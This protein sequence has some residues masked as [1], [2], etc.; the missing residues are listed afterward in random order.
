MSRRP[1]CRHWLLVLWCVAVG[2]VASAASAAAGHP[3]LLLGAGETAALRDEWP[4]SNLFAAAVARAEARLAPYLKDP[5]EVPVPRDA[6]GGGTHERH[7]ANAVLLADAG[8]L[9]QWTGEARYAELA[10]QLLLRYAE[11]YPGL[12]LHPER[13][14]GTPG[15]LFWQ[16]LNESV[17]LVHAILGYDCIR[18]ALDV[19]ERRRIE[20]DLL[21]PMARFLSIDSSRMFNSVHNHGTWA[22]AAVGM[23]GYVL[24]DE[25]MVR[26]ALLGTGE[27]G[28]G[29]YLLQLA[30]LFLSAGLL[31]GGTVLPALCVDAVR[32]VRQGHRP[33]RAGA[34]HLRPSRRC[35]AEGDPHHHPTQLCRTFLSDQRRHPAKK[36][37]TRW[38]WTTP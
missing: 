12:G 20:N 6:G 18:D 26:M 25:R 31:L 21:R 27:D 16:S 37:W 30:Q 17:W 8:A 13:S 22:A 34:P 28:N 35:A 32:A 11:L 3:R 2:Q 33:Q 10:R 15:R 23:T 24:D 9:Y 38:S 19:D 7:K 5:P 14:S 1:T 4:K 29:G 36:G